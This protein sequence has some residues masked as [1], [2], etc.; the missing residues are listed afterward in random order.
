MKALCVKSYADLQALVA[1]QVPTIEAT[2]VEQDVA[3]NVENGLQQLMPYVVFYNMDIPA[4]KLKFIQFLRPGKVVEGSE[5]LTQG[6]TSIGFD[7]A[8]SDAAAV[9]ATE[10]ITNEAGDTMF[11][12]SLQNIMDT[13]V[14]NGLNDVLSM[15]GIDLP[16]TL[17]AQFIDQ[18]QIAFF[19]SDVNL[20]DM[21]VRTG[22]A[23]PIPVSAEQFEVL[24]TTAV[25]KPEEI[26][27]L[28]TLGI[29]IDMIVE[30][31]DV[32]PT[33]NDVVNELV[34]KYNLEPWST[35]MFNY[36][37]RKEL[38]EML[39]DISYNDIVAL[40]HAKRAALAQIAQDTVAQQRA[41]AEATAAAN[42]SLSTVADADA[43]GVEKTG[44]EVAV[45]EVAETSGDGKEVGTAAPAVVED[46]VREE[47]QG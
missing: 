3:N 36:I 7:K 35:M 4:G 26:E 46:E 37:A 43:D 20:D 39:K 45:G 29:N 44:V 18:K 5:E 38:Y 1:G 19:N 8:I 10:T 42:A 12:M 11:V 2:L 41:A 28:D 13:A 6:T 14:S 23:L 40:V 33:I 31:M 15:T 16:A 21:K 27:K 34:G 24:R 25:F 22:I 30:R 17:G 47:V 9:V 32:T